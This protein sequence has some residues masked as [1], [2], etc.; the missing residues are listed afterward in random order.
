MTQCGCLKDPECGAI[1]VVSEPGVISCVSDP[2]P[3]GSR[4]QIEIDGKRTGQSSVQ[5][6]DVPAGSGGHLWFRR[7]DPHPIP[8]GVVVPGAFPADGRDGPSRNRS[9][10]RRLKRS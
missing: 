6:A 8:V 7:R 10:N 1:D 5:E 3:G 4:C 9:V 2:E